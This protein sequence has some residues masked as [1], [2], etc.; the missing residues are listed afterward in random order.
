MGETT[1]G[2]VALQTFLQRFLGYALTGETC[3]HAL[4]Y[5]LGEGGNG[6]SVFVNT[7]RG[8]FGDYAAVAAPDLL[9]QGAERRAG[10]AAHSTEIAMLAGA[11]LVTASETEEGRV[12]AD[13]RLKLLTGG[14]PVTARFRRARPFHLHA[15]LQADR[16]RQPHAGAAHRRRR[17]PP[18]PLRRAVRHPPGRARPRGW[19]PSCGRN[20]PASC[21]G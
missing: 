18:A 13:G 5:G 21:A 19:R 12:W 15:A 8:I 9:A 3:E 7:V 17:A 6:K 2:E 20:G 4:L 16:R 11:R 14:D 10:K 1:G